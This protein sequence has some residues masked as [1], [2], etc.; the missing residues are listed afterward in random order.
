MRLSLVVATARNHVI[1]FEGG[2]PW[3]LPDDQRFFRRLTTGHAVVMGRKTFESIGR[4]LPNRMNLVL[5]RG[6]LPDRED[7]HVFSNL[8]EAE[9]WARQHEITELFVIGGEAVY[10]D[11]LDRADRIYRTCVEAEPEGDVF[12]PE[13]DERAWQCI[14]RVPHA[15]D[16]RH[17][18]AFCIETWERRR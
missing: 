9:D 11:A 7:V 3:R 8:A 5:S 16:D 2:I 6:V 13:I 4:A 17:A 18:H 12:F 14:E 10:R 15:I 1:G